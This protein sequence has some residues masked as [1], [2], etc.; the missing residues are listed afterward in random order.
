MPVTVDT[1]AS[2]YATT[3]DLLARYDRRTVAKLASDDGQPLADTALP[4][5]GPVV[6]ALLGGS[7]EVEAACLKGQRYRPTDLAALT[8]STK[9]YL[10][11]LVCDLAFE[12]LRR[13]RPNPGVEPAPAFKEAREALEQL[14]TGARLF[15]TI[16][17]EEAG[18]P[19][20][21]VETAVQVEARNLGTA[22]AERY[23]SRRGNRQSS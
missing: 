11:Q 13:R 23:W 6:A 12:R 2:G 16:Q 14:A 10:L 4:T 8:G 3:D 1:S 20:S 21:E 7:G 5:A 15:G 18:L 19:A 22:I 9:E 17:H